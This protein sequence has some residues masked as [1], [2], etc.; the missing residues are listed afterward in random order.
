MR[1][2][3]AGG[4]R[5]C[6]HL[7]ALKEVERAVGQDALEA[8]GLEIHTTLDL[9]VQA[10]TGGSLAAPGGLCFAHEAPPLLSIRNSP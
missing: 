8:G 6:A 10:G 1:L 2:A 9:H 7:Q 3:L 4:R 5:R